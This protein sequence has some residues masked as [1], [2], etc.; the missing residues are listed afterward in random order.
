MI[1]S[2]KS[3]TEKKKVKKGHFLKNYLREFGTSNDFP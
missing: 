2:Y 1:R 3:Y